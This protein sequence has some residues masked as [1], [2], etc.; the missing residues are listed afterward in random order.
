MVLS[1]VSLKSG[2]E[3]T[4]V[5]FYQDI[6]YGGTAI[7]LGPGNYNLSQLNEAGIPNDWMSSLKVPSGYT[8]EVYQHDNFV[9]LHVEY[10]LRWREL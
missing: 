1:V 2:A 5:T 9:D 6:N 8:V 4:G 7:T 10:F 3:V